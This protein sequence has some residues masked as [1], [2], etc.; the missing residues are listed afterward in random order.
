MRALTW[1]DGIVARL[2][3]GRHRNRPGGRLREGLGRSPRCLAGPPPLRTICAWCRVVL[4]E[5]EGAVAREVSHGICPA[6]AEHFRVELSGCAEGSGP[7]ARR[8]PVSGTAAMQPGEWEG[9]ND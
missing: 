9:Q 6:C 5:G 4:V 8:L 2:F 7:P 3:I 1:L